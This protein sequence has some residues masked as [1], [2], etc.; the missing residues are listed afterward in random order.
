MRNGQS[1]A[2]V[3]TPQ[4][5]LPEFI[6]LEQALVDKLEVLQRNLDNELNQ[7]SEDDQI[8]ISPSA[9]NKI[10]HILINAQ[11]ALGNIARTH[12]HSNKLLNFY[13]D[14]NQFVRMV[15]E[16]EMMFCQTLK[17][18]ASK[19]TESDTSDSESLSEKTAEELF[20][21]FSADN[22]NNLLADHLDLISQIE[23][24]GHLSGAIYAA[25]Q[26][27]DRN[28]QDPIFLVRFFD[29]RRIVCKAIEDVHY[30]IHPCVEKS[31]QNETRADRTAQREHRRSRESEAERCYEFGLISL[32]SDIKKQ[33]RAL[34]VKNNEAQEK[35][36][37]ILKMIC[38]LSGRKPESSSDTDSSRSSTSSESSNSDTMSDSSRSSSH[39][40]SG[41]FSRS[42][43]PEPKNPNRSSSLG[44][45]PG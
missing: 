36:I 38:S 28:A 40:S 12:A 42:R 2:A 22:K 24:I 35:R 11:R 45:R 31:N 17:N 18:C 23:R 9:R 37:K 21:E 14:V 39:S 16:M 19:K 6:K 8:E 43:S 29:A 25:S 4:E 20:A 15:D 26:L 44:A 41:L 10:R 32:S 3:V 13:R 5:T 33:M 30:A 27:V 1:H 34:L 7:I